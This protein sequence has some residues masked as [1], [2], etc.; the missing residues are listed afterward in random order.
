MKILYYGY[1][2]WSI[3]IFNSLKSD[4]KYLI[5]FDDYSLVEKINADIIFFIGWSK[6]VPLEIIRKYK[7]FC[8]HPSKLPDYR[9]GSPLQHQIIS[10]EKVS[11]VTIFI[12]N[13]VLDGGDIIYQEE[14]SIEGKLNEIFK[15]IEIIGARLLNRIIDD[16][17]NN[18]LD[19]KKQ[20][21]SES[22]IYKRRKF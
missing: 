15:D 22:K 10:G 17:K 3:N 7:C 11:A 1:R 9:G 16:V 4:E 8:L 2:D 21:L 18:K 13:E 20:N 12:M 19:R 6:I 14:F 5:S